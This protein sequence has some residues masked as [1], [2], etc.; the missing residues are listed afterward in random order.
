MSQI[1]IMPTLLDLMGYHEPF[2]AFGQSIFDDLSGVSAS[3]IGDKFI[4]FATYENESYMLLYQDEA[5]LG[6][7]SL[8]DVM[9]TKNLMENSALSEAL[10]NALKAMIQ[11]YNH[12]LIRNEMTVK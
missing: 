3:Y 2:F 9:Q 5:V 4:F 8:K 7:F 11:T 10:V 6:I 12:A 1:D